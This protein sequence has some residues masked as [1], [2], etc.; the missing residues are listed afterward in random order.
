MELTEIPDHPNLEPVLGPALELRGMLARARGEIRDFHA[1]GGSGEQVCSALTTLCDRV[2]G[3]AY[4][5]VDAQTGRRDR[6]AN[7]LAIV[8]VGGYGRGDLAPC[9]DV[10]LLFLAARPVDHLLKSFISA[11]VRLLWDAGLS[12]SQSV[13]TPQDSVA[14]AREDLI[15]WTALTEARLLRGNLTLFKD[16]KARIQKLILRRSVRRL[17]GHLLAERQKE[18]VGDPDSTVYLLEPDI[19]KSAGGLREY[20]LIRWVGRTRYGLADPAALRDHGHLSES[21]CRQVLQTRELLLRIRNE[22]HFQAGSAQD[23]LTL[24]EQVRIA[25]WLGWTNTEVSLPVERFMQDYYRHTTSL[26]EIALRFARAAWAGRRPAWR[27][28]VPPRRIEPGFVIGNGNLRLSRSGRAIADERRAETWLRLFELAR[29]H[30]AEIDPATLERAREMVPL[31]RVTPEARRLFLQILDYPLDLGRLLRDLH[32]IGLL[33]RLIPAFEHTRC[34]IQFNQYHRFTVDEHT[35]RAVEHAVR[36]S[37]DRD[38]VGAAYRRIRRKALLHLAILLHDAGKGYTLDHSEKGA[39]LAA[40]VARDFAL[41]DHDRELLVFLVRHH[42]IMAHT[43]QRR[44][45]SDPQTI[46]RFARAVHTPEALSKLFVL[47]IVDTEAVSPGN[48]TRWKETL[49]SQLY[50]RTMQE[51]TG[52]TIA[53]NA[54]KQAAEIRRQLAASSP[55]DTDWLVH[56]LAAMPDGYLLST[57]ISRIG[58]HLSALRQHRNGRFV[59]DMQFDPNTGISTYT[60]VTGEGHKPGLFAKVAGV[61]AG[62]GFQILAAQI[63]TRADD[64]ALDTFE[65]IDLDFSGPPPPHRREGIERV[66]RDVLDGRR[67]VESLFGRR[68]TPPSRKPVIQRQPTQVDIDNTSSDRFTIVEVFADDRQG[69]LHVITQALFELGVSI[70]SAKIATHVDQV[71]DVFYVTEAD[72]SKLTDETRLEAIARELARRIDAPL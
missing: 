12:V 29:C 59:L 70:H 27:R 51:L 17:A 67:T 46:A 3:R 52:Q 20:H 26:H 69:L 34:L 42:L 64:I 55:F 32:Q 6:V 61:L 44:D 54:A 2:I 50:T 56:Q 22:L 62:C 49:L 37:E 40:G 15:A 33:G 18:Q 7:E 57:D 53:Q 31:A 41:S 66:L 13:R 16:L 68:F 60:L 4:E 72:G 9:S 8:A 65:T 30:G 10:D 39:E 24:D 28:L 48:L 14:F 21:D 58:M 35:L 11:M 1:R 47:T 63:L 43:S 36:R 23:T 25:R 5:L 38:V 19:K 71:V 45:I